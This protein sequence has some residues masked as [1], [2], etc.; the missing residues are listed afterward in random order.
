MS[1]WS[2]CPG[3][4]IAVACVLTTA[5][6]FPVI[7]RSDDGEQ[8]APEDAPAQDSTPEQE[9]ARAAYAKLVRATKRHNNLAEKHGGDASMRDL[10]R[11]TASAHEKATQQF[12]EAFAASDWNAWD[13][14][15]D[16]ALL[17][18]GLMRVGSSAI[19]EDAAQAL[20]AFELMV[21]KV[22][23]APETAMARVQLPFALTIL[24]DFEKAAAAA[25]DAATREGGR[26]GGVLF[27]LVGDI[28][29]AAADV[30]R[31]RTAY[32]RGAAMYAAAAAA[33]DAEAEDPP[34]TE[35]EGTEPDPGRSEP[36]Q[37]AR[38]RRRAAARAESMREQAE[39]LEVRGRYIGEIAPTLPPANWIGD[40]P[41]DPSESGERVALLFCMSGTRC[42]Q[43]R[44]TLA[45]LVREHAEHAGRGVD[46]IVLSKQADEGVLPGARR[47]AGRRPPLRFSAPSQYVE[48]L[49]EVREL[50]GATFPIGVLE[51][52]RSRGSETAASSSG[53]R[54]ASAS[55]PLRPACSMRVSSARSPRLGSAGGVGPSR[56]LARE[57]PSAHARCA[58][59]RARRTHG[60]HQGGPLNRA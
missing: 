11:A 39:H 44:A 18:N 48:H 51:A 9:R 7:A 37:Q 31:A 60:G 15:K 23:H 13:P 57:S 56:P 42:S 30:P 22:P 6:A 50:L 24:G 27:E 52:A 12:V 16:G 40:A 20:R 14:S 43:C 28:A 58:R 25:T 55:S 49:R 26:R 35:T 41:R 32:Q 10:L 21:A 33:L 47:D 45:Q 1:V 29:C 53:G 17:A 5:L 59:A 46:V 54:K 2:R 3:R 19:F 8:P 4:E 36:D 38:R 34:P